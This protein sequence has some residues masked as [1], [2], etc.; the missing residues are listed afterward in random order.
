MPTSD[1]QREAARRNGAKSRGPKTAEGKARSSRNA[2]RHGLLASTLVLEDECPDAFH[3]L[4][5]A[6]YA[7]FEPA[8]PVEEGFVDEMIASYWRL[9]RLWTIETSLLN[10]QLDQIP[11]TPDD[12]RVASA[13]ANL[14]AV[15]GANVEL[16]A[17]HETR[18]SR[19]FTRAL[20]NLNKVRAAAPPDSPAPAVAAEPVLP[21]EPG[22]APSAAPGTPVAPAPGSSTAAEARP[23]L[24]DRTRGCERAADTNPS[25]SAASPDLPARPV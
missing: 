1:K 10:R 7:R 24:R 6:F 9:R 13:F 3:E 14:A 20:D 8:D 22:A 11:D 25:P 18:L 12:D 15:P 17:R 21:N 5:S 23:P 4:Q 19:T 2:L 16:L